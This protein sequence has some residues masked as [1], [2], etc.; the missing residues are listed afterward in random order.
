LNFRPSFVFYGVGFLAL[1][2]VLARTYYLVWK[3][4]KEREEGAFRSREKRAGK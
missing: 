3:M 2:F 4:K 1:L